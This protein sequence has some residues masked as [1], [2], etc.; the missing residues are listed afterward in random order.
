LREDSVV[1]LGSRPECRFALWGKGGKHL[2]TPLQESREIQLPPEWGLV[3]RCAGSQAHG[4][5]EPERARGDSGTTEAPARIIG[6]GV[7]R[8]GP[9][10]GPRSSAGDPQDLYRGRGQTKPA[11]KWRRHSGGQGLVKVWV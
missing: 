3:H 9:H 11:G 10:M 4:G 5:P 1:R 7:E 8:S 6:S 2:R